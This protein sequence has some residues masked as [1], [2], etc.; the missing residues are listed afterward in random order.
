MPPKSTMHEP[1]DSPLDPAMP[2]VNLHSHLE[3]S[4]R[5]A[6]Y[7]ELCRAMGLPAP[8]SLEEA[9]ALLSVDGSETCLHDY[10][11]RITPVG[12]ILKGVAALERTSYE[13]AEDA[14]R[15]GVAYFELRAG[16][17]LHLTPTVD[18]S[19]TIEAM[20]RGLQEAERALGIAARLIV[21]ALRAHDPLDNEALARVAVRY[22]GRGVVGFDLA[23]DEKGYPA[24]H[25]ARAYA[26]AAAGGLGLTCHAGEGEGSASIVEAAESLGA[27][28]IGHG[29][30]LDDTPGRVAWAKAEGLVLEICPT[31]N[32]DTR[33]V[34]SLADHPVR[35]LFDAGLRISI[36]DDDPTTSRTRIARELR[37]L[38]STFGFTL[39]ELVQI[40]RTG[41][42]AAFAEPTATAP[43]RAQLD[44]FAARTVS[45]SS[46]S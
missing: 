25:H 39:P 7:L 10:L 24:R 16:P 41:L 17:L 37:L 32:V 42:E 23:G 43:I 2:L 27:R 46:A 34:P 13:A 9:Q 3:G 8:N 22:A 29:T 45:L 5:P 20:L 31:S 44:A 18:T 36:G 11:E 26:I 14:R 33:A 4:I 40:Q 6:T 35:R 28:R 19:A 15:D 38:A 30:H 1:P 12:P 21:C